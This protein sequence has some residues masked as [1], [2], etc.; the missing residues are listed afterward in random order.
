MCSADSPKKTV[1]MPDLIGYT[2]TDAIETLTELGL[3]A[4]ANSI[5]EV[6]S[7]SIPAGTQLE[8]GS[9]IVL[10]LINNDTE[11]MG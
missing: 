8:K 3:N 9:V 4:Q 7:Q 6:V 2:L 11:S 1:T 10:D 5:G